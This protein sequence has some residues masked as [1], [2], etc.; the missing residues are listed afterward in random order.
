[1]DAA[2]HGS[3][4]NKLILVGIV[5]SLMAFASPA[6]AGD[7]EVQSARD[8]RESFGLRDDIEYVASS[9]SDSQR[10]SNTDWGVPL[11]TAEA[12][13]LA[14]RLQVQKSLGPAIDHAS[15]QPGYGGAYIDQLDGG[16]PVFLFTKDV[17][18]HSAEIGTFLEVGTRYDVRKVDHSLAAL[19]TL[20]EE[21]SAERDDLM[22]ADVEV[23]SVSVDVKSNRVVVGVLDKTDRKRDIVK[24]LGDPIVVIDETLPHTDT[25]LIDD[26]PNLK[27]GLK[28]AATGATCTSGYL[29]R[30]TDGSHDDIVMVTAGHCIAT[31]S[32]A[33]WKHNGTGF[34]TENP[35]HGWNNNSAAD[36]GFI[37]V[38]SGHVPSNKNTF[39][40]KPGTGTSA[41]LTG[42][43]TFSQQIIG[44]Q[45]CR[46]GWGS[47]NYHSSNSYYT[48]RQCGQIITYDTDTA[49]T[50]DNNSQSCVDGT[51]K[52]IQ[53]M[54]AVD[55]DS[56]AGDSGG[57]IF[58]QNS[59]VD[60]PTKLLGT[61]VHSQDTG[62]YPADDKGWYSPYTQGTIRFGNDDIDIDG[63]FSSSC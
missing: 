51:C 55:F 17:A 2:F 44:M 19:T 30:R 34:G 45:V 7:V 9:L 39:L 43:R 32:D 23:V 49:S 36:V 22:K 56:W 47:S 62:G 11:T 40:S 41:A 14:S 20:K 21:V 18:T 27:G 8:F 6:T 28:I 52:Y 1:M 37:T 24:G 50:T 29:G 61:H 54:K 46:I 5:A 31:S 26:C 48:A 42:Y 38:W 59:P 57:T 33:T 15:K 10:F 4:R 58:E 25:C 16:L 13:D 63:C 12:D 53:K 60:D 35:N 3:H